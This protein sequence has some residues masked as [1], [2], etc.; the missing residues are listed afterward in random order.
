MGTEGAGSLT[1]LGSARPLC[2]VVTFRAWSTEGRI[3]LSSV[4]TE[5][6]KVVCA[7]TCSKDIY[8]VVPCGWFRGTVVELDLLKW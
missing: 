8:S 5:T 3:Q 7:G 1:A 2:V 4:D 6:G